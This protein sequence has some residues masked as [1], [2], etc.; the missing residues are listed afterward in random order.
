MEPN[1]SAKI[2]TF[3]ATSAGPRLLE[4]WAQPQ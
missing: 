1:Q 3:S 2:P 4:P